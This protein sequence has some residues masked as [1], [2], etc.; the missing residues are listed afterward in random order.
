MQVWWLLC[1]TCRLQYSLPTL[2][3][4]AS[5]SSPHHL[6]TIPSELLILKDPKQ[7]TTDRSISIMSQYQYR[8]LD[9]AKQEI[10]L[11][12]LH[13]GGGEAMV[14]V[15]IVHHSLADCPAYEALSYVWGDPTAT[16]DI[17]ILAPPPAALEIW[18]TGTQEAIQ[19][20]PIEPIVPE[21]HSGDIAASSDDSSRDGSHIMY[22]LRV[23]TN[24]K[25]A[26]QHLRTPTK[27]RMIWI[28]ALCINQ[29]DDAERG[30][31]VR[32]MD[33]I[34]RNCSRV[35]IWLGDVEEDSD[36]A[37]ELI[38]SI[39]ESHEAAMRDKPQREITFDDTFTPI[40]VLFYENEKFARH[41]RALLSLII[42]PWFSRLWIVQEVVLSTRRVVLC[43]NHQAD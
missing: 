23:T 35:C 1:W 31:Q 11:L 21:H 2:R 41:F 10:R 36:L 27:P 9:S 25:S 20:P 34:Y 33:Q 5:S 22:I 16:E 12:I 4:P 14:E 17:H 42:R 29:E 28:D 7:I 38:N 18:S 15:E 24:L 3:Q 30:H 40:A 43:G 32:Q 13:P 6:T 8:P 19:G 26:L 39:A 37:M